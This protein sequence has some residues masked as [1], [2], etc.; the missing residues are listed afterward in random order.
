[1]A[2]G[3]TSKKEFLAKVME[4]KPNQ[5]IAKHLQ[6]GEQENSKQLR[7][8][9]EK[10]KLLYSDWDQIFR[11]DQCVKWVELGRVTPPT[12]LY[13]MIFCVTHTL[14]NYSWVMT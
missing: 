13:S 14:L 7:Q 10:L 11:G 5:V 2:N 12:Q 9:K 3:V 6:K 1:M 8:E 4:E